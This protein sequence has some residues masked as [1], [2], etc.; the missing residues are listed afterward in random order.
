[1]N[2]ALQSHQ[3]S[4]H[5]LFQQGVT[6]NGI[7]HVLRAIR[8]HL[9]MD[10]AYI[11]RFRDDDR[12][13]EHVDADGQAPLQPGQ[14]LPA[15]QGYCF[16][17]AS[18]ELPAL[19]QDT[20]FHPV[21]AAVPE[22]RT[23]GMAAHLGV[24]I[25]LRDGHLYG[26]LCFFSHKP[27]HLLAERDVALLQAF[28][29][30]LSSHIEE[31]IQKEADV[32]EK[33]DLVRRA[34]SGDHLHLLAQPIY[35]LRNGQLS[36]VECLSRF[37]LTPA[38]TTEEWFAMAEEV[39]FRSQLEEA[40]VRKAVPALQHLPAGLYL[41]VNSSPELVLH[42]TLA[43]LLQGQPLSHLVVEVTEHA[44]IDDYPA[45]DAALKPLRAQGLCLAID[46]A[47]AGYASM[48]HIVSLRP[49]IIKLD[50]SLV[51]HIDQDGSRRALAKALITFANEVGSH[52]VAEGIETEAELEVLLQLGV[53]SGQGFLLQ[54][55]VPLAEG[56]LP[57]LQQRIRTSVAQDLQS[58]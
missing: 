1:M 50:M 11:S 8:K 2:F 56:R 19:I 3:T 28:A 40:A 34:I 7:D 32:A 18:G 26:T 16:K 53:H 5:E 4:I 27:N 20:F 21:A 9:G 30:V 51:R 12:I 31:L 57:G 25:R 17:V 23:L 41:G 6:T 33:R 46:D 36:G 42:G 15:S 47:G 13:F 24:A 45:F 37:T 35:D 52:L 49:D 14:V 58:R 38:R 48:R 54:P 44:L 10:V 43:A 22:T 39:G 55:P 29:E